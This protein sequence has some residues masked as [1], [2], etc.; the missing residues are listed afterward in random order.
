MARPVK[1]P[2]AARTGRIFGAGGLDPVKRLAA[3]TVQY[4][5]TQAAADDAIM[6][7]AGEDVV[8]V[9]AE[10]VSE[11]IT[12]LRFRLIDGMTRTMMIRVSETSD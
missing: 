9:E 6:A 10:Q 12:L 8:S 7:G 5:V 2:T 4:L 3:I 1:A 11:L